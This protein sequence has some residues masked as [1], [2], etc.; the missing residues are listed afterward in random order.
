[1]GKPLGFGG[2]LGY[3]LHPGIISQLFADPPSTTHV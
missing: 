1:V 3:C 2:N